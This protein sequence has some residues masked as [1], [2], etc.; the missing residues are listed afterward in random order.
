MIFLIVTTVS[1]VKASNLT[2]LPPSAP[3]ATAP[4]PVRT[5][6]PA[7]PPRNNQSLPL[8]KQI[9]EEVITKGNQ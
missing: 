3:L 2:P 8:V 1:E 6:A 9:N 7:L 5:E 4:R